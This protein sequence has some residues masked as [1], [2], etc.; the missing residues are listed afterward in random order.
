MTPTPVQATSSPNLRPDAMLQA[1]SFRHPGTCGERIP[2]PHE[3][4]QQALAPYMAAERF[5]TRRAVL[6][7][8]RCGAAW[9]EAA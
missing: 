4:C 6:V 8:C 9:R 2:S 1:T 3:R 5:T 7:L